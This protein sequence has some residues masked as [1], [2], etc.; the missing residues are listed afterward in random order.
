VRKSC[1]HLSVVATTLLTLILSTAAS[2][3]QN[4]LT[5]QNDIGRTGRQLN[6]SILTTGNV[7]TATFGKVF[8]YTVTGQ[9]YAQPLTVANVNITCSGNPHCNFAFPA[10]VVYVATEDDWLYAFDATG[11]APNPYWSVNLAT[12]A[13]SGGTYVNCTQVYSGCN[14][15]S[16][17]YPHVGVTGT[18]VI[19]TASN[20]LYV[21]SAVSASGVIADWLHAIDLGNG[22]EKFGGP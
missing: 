16:A 17:L 20:T 12:N 8:T 18:P 7:N 11:A 1:R 19:D 6:E 5:R 10:N 14:A 3:A 22:N 4:V 2:S 21:V 9:I 13:V 15:N